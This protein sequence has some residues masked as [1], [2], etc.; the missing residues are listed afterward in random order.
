MWNNKMTPPSML[1]LSPFKG[2]SLF[3]IKTQVQFS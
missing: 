2:G 3:M 1:A